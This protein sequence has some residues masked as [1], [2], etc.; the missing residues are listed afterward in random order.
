[1][2][3]SH[4]IISV[5]I[6]TSTI[7]SNQQHLSESIPIIIL[8]VIQVATTYAP[9]FRRIIAMAAKM[10][11]AVAD[12]SACAAVD[13]MARRAG[14]RAAEPPSAGRVRC[15]GGRENWGRNRS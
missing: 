6:S 11:Q 14:R 2:K 3:S 1:M 4:T 10:Q 13:A 8:P 5:N 7:N 12:A 9:R 15:P